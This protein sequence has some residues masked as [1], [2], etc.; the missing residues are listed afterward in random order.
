MILLSIIALFTSCTTSVK[1]VSKAKRAV[2]DLSE[3]H[4][5][6][7]PLNPIIRLNHN[8]EFNCTA[9][10]IGNNYA[11]TAGHCVMN[12]D[13]ETL[14]DHLT[15]IS[16]DQKITRPVQA[17]DA[18]LNVDIGLIS[19]NFAEFDHVPVSNDELG[20]DGQLMSCGYPGGNKQLTCAGIVPQLNDGFMIKATGYVVGGESGGPIIN[21]NTSRVVGIN[22]RVYPADIG[23]GMGYGPTMGILA[24][25]GIEP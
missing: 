2:L 25:L 4:N 5:L 15:I 23:G 3:Q 24:W 7:A 17:V 18:N 12:D 14:T 19:G 21:L 11:L 6:L 13:F 10:V 8:G 9:I 16:N 1:E 20:V 22:S